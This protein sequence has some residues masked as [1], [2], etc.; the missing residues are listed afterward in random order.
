MKLSGFY[1]AIKEA[2]LTGTDIEDVI[3]IIKTHPVHLKT[4]IED[5]IRAAHYSRR[6]NGMYG[7]VEEFLTAEALVKNP[8]RC[9]TMVSLGRGQD[10]FFGNIDD[11]SLDLSKQVAMDISV[12][13]GSSYKLDKGS[14]CYCGL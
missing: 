9:L 12:K 8:M 11:V 14:S 5:V 6:K 10:S 13:R 7:S 1:E 4:D 3:S 2:K